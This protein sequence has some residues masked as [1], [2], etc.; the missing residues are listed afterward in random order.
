M[1]LQMCR[2]VSESTERTEEE[3]LIVTAVVVDPLISVE[4]RFIRLEEA[5]DAPR[6]RC[7]D[8][9]IESPKGILRIVGRVLEEFTLIASA[10]SSPSQSHGSFTIS[11]A[12]TVI[13]SSSSRQVLSSRRSATLMPVRH[14]GAV[15][16]HSLARM[17]SKASYR[18]TS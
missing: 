4:V 7:D 8:A 3:D 15:F 16:L 18:A 14:A 2:G 10:L 13:S 17:S 6:E 12:E 1:L 5:G 11:I 9:D